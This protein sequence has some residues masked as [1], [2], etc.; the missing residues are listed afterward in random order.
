MMAKA[1]ANGTAFQSREAATSAFT[2][3]YRSQPEFQNKFTAEPKA[4]PAWLPKDRVYRD[5]AGA[6]YSIS[7]N[8]SYGG[9]GYMGPGN[10]F[11]MYDPFMDIM[12]LN[13]LMSNHSYHYP[14]TAAVVPSQVVPIQPIMPAHTVEQPR[15]S[16]AWVWWLIIPA[17]IVT[18]SVLASRAS[19]RG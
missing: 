6:S 8:Q 10:R 17:V 14:P 4:P 12:M 3:K 9:Y 11:M 5:S 16:Y 7:Y 2:A 15:R 13:L 19:R 18:V 1:R